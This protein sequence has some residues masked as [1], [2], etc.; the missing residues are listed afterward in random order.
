[1][2]LRELAQAVLF[3]MMSGAGGVSLAADASTKGGGLEP[4]RDSEA[5]YYVL[6]GDDLSALSL[7]LGA[8]SS[9]ELP[10]DDDTAFKQFNA[11][12]RYGLD[13][14]AGEFLQ[15]MTYQGR[16][17]DRVDQA[18]LRLARLRYERG[19]L[20]EAEEA[21]ARVRGPLAPA[22]D[23]A[24]RLLKARILEARSDEDGAVLVL[25]AAVAQYPQSYVARYNLGVLQL[26]TGR[27]TD[28]ESTLDELGQ[29]SAKTDEQKTLRDRANVVLGYAA[30]RAQQPD[31]A[32][33]YLERVS[34]QGTES[35]RALL[36]YGWAAMDQKAPQAALVPWLEL[37]KRDAGDPAV[38]EAKLAVPYAYEQLGAKAKA[39][40]S[41]AN[42]IESFEAQRAALDSSMAFIRSGQWVDALLRVRS[43]QS[44]AWQFDELPDVP[45]A[46][47]LLNVLA[48]S[49][50]QGIYQNLLD[51]RGL[52]QKLQS[53][54]IKV[55]QLNQAVSDRRRVLDSVQRQL[56]VSGSDERI[57]S[58][59]R[60]LDALTSE[61]AQ[62]E[63][64]GDG[65]TFADPQELDW[66]DRIARIQVQARKY[67]NA[68]D[69]KPVLERIAVVSGLL[70]WQLQQEQPARLAAA[71]DEVAFI[72]AG[73]VAGRQHQQS[74]AQTLKDEPQRLARI[75][76]RVKELQMGL[77]D[78]T[79]K[80]AQLT[81]EQRVAMQ[82]MA[83]MELSRQKAHL[84]SYLTQARFAMAQLYDQAVVNDKSEPN[85]SA[86]QTDKQEP[87]DAN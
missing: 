33:R 86:G 21:L 46:D 8:T 49:S 5:L 70:K 84:T 80:I 62:A 25:R 36:G 57:Q 71:K 34:L 30:L 77:D 18:W 35:N 75:E 56:A 43:G 29:S 11:M 60:R 2:R 31:S 74:I 58:L 85:R 32:R 12:A 27:T 81:Q 40:Q 73:L 50:F 47:S 4:S 3:V 53:I 48:E 83:L 44:D 41:Y 28:G 67:A 20:V 22:L 82:T 63:S 38:Q 52:S 16:A 66:L 1:M 23:E 7:W 24:S 65:V 26:S 68:P 72:K 39:L 19:H 78:V 76:S 14:E 17:Q 15:R 87:R 59:A 61:I 69:M 13:R 37:S 64:K 79:R 45:Y 42:V 55:G 6:Q 10:R 51:L 9:I 54:Q